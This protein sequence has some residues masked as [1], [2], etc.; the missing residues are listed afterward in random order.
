MSNKCID[1]A[2]LKGN[3]VQVDEGPFENLKLKFLPWWCETE[4]ARGRQSAAASGQVAPIL[5]YLWVSP[6]PHA[7]SSSSA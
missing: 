7:S 5:S 6:G 4:K 2:S 3:F 1:S